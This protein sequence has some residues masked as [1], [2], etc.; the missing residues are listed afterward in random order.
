M[1]YFQ[2]FTLLLFI[3]INLLACAEHEEEKSEVYYDFEVSP[4]VSDC[5][6]IHWG[7]SKEVVLESFNDST[8][9][10]SKH[11]LS[12][13]R[14][15]FFALKHGAESNDSVLLSIGKTYLNLLENEYLKI[16]SDSTCIYAYEFDH[17]SFKS[18][19]W[20]SAMANSVIALAQLKA[21]NLYGDSS[22]YHSFNRSFNAIVAPTSNGGCALALAP[23]AS[24]Y[25]EYADSNAT[26]DNSYFVLNGF[27]F[28]LTNIKQM[29]KLLPQKRLENA[30]DRGVEAFKL[31]QN[32]FFYQNYPWTY[33]ML[34]PQTIESV[35]Y[36]I[37]DMLLFKALFQLDANSVWKDEVMK[38]SNLIHENY[39]L[40]LYESENDEVL[41]F[42]QV[43]V[44]HPYWVDTY[45]S[46]IRV[47][48]KN[49]EDKVILLNKPR[50]TDI[51]LADRAFY[52][53]KDVQNEISGYEMFSIYA[54]D[55]FLLYGVK[56]SLKPTSNGIKSSESSSS[57]KVYQGAKVDSKTNAFIPL[58]ENSPLVRASLSADIDPN[59]LDSSIY[60]ALKAKANFKVKSVRM[61]LLTHLGSAERYYEPITSNEDNLMVVS[62][63]GF[64]NIDNIDLSSVKAFRLDI[65]AD[66]SLITDSSRI[67]VSKL[68]YIQNNLQ[69]FNLLKNSH[70]HFPEYDQKGNIY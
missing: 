19:E 8:L 16:G 50:Q 33:Y 1:H 31:K 52:V 6:P 69:L 67:E 39:P 11:P 44:P 32:A 66:T 53:E 41:F 70:A 24:W 23:N 62:P 30:Y 18:G 10:K 7:I 46:Y 57:F 59:K 63:I 13:G 2:R 15:A 34:N 60:L 3:A 58:V 68:M 55:T 27:L 47:H 48:F 9:F 43:G 28:V 42:S 29:E 22:Y 65:Y 38:R 45:T 21:F 49:T 12:L 14:H 61:T 35:H 56:G 5:S 40:E 17:H 26:I 20:W 25:L 36:A 51:R 54:K 37:F 4:S 64:K